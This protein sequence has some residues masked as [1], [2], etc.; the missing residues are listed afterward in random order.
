MRPPPLNARE[1]ACDRDCEDKMV[2]GF[3]KNIEVTV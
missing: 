2:T 1:E 3:F